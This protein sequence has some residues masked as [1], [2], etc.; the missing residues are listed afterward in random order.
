MQIVGSRN[1]IDKM[2]VP[3]LHHEFD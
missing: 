2:N 1:V 3:S